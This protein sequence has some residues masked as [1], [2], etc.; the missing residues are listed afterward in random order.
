M[1]TDVCVPLSM[2]PDAIS[3]ASSLLEKYGLIGGIVGH[4][5]DGN[6]HALIMIDP[7]DPIESDKAHTVNQKI[8][9][10]A[11]DCGGTATGEHGIGLGKIDYLYKEHASS[12][13]LM[14]MIK[15]QFDPLGI[16]N[17]GKMFK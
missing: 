14:K 2:L 13:H 6:F 9:E 10:F 17:P 15:G 8:V 1:S 5:G 12:I 7:N 16:L 11:I 3:H 4:V